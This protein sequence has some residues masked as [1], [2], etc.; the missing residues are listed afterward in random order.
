MANCH[1]HSWVE[2]SKKHPSTRSPKL[3]LEVS[4]ANHS[5][6]KTAYRWKDKA[7]G[8]AILQTSQ[9]EKEAFLKLLCEYHHM[10]T[11]IT[12]GAKPSMVLEAASSPEWP[13]QS[14]FY[15]LFLFLLLEGWCLWFL[16]SSFFFFF[17]CY[18]QSLLSN[19]VVSKKNGEVDP[20]ACL[21]HLINRRTCTHRFLL[22]HR[23]GWAKWRTLTADLPGINYL[24]CH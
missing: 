12:T 17:F 21:Y 22:N 19:T 2:R 1:F 9:F 7:T 6:S 20:N 10:P 16:F 14:F 24:K 11:V 8:D 23:A 5:P 13:Q 15:S 4:F 18:Q 3:V